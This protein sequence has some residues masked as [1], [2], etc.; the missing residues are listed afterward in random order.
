MQYFY[1]LLVHAQK[2]TY[3]FIDSQINLFCLLHEVEL[4]C[5][6]AE[7]RLLESQWSTEGRGVMDI[8]RGIG[9]MRKEADR[10]VTE[11]LQ[12][13]VRVV[14]ELWGRG[15]GEEVV[16]VRECVEEYLRSEGGWSE[17]LGEY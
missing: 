3:Q 16:G 8:E 2:S 13:R 11:E 17:A 10:R 7:C 1:T 12:E 5:A 9:A 15:F 14:E 6:S 4:A